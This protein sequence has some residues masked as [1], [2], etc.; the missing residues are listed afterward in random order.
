M[1]TVDEGQLSLTVTDDGVGVAVGVGEAPEGHG[2]RNM[3][4]RAQNLGGSFAVAA[5]PSDGTTLQ[6]KVPI[7][8]LT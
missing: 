7:P 8:P 3:E 1:V 4:T 2:L 5:A 6:W